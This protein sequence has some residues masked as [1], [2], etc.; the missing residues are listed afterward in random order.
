MMVLWDQQAQGVRYE[1]TVSDGEHVIYEVLSQL[2]QLRSHQRNVWHVLHQA[3]KVQGR[4]EMLVDLLFELSQHVPASR[5][6]NLAAMARQ[7]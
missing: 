4:L 5:Q 6:Q 3:A 7:V 2:K 1:T